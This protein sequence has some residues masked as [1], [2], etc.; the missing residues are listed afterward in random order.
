MPPTRC[1]TNRLH[2]TP[3]PRHSCIR[4]VSG[5]GSVSRSV[6]CPMNSRSAILACAWALLL[7]ACHSPRATGDPFRSAT[8]EEWQRGVGIAKQYAL[9][10]LGL[11]QDQLSKLKPDVGYVSNRGG[12]EKLELQFYDPKL[13]P[14]E[15]DTVQGLFIAMDGGFP[16]YFRI[17]IDPHSW[18]VCD[19]YASP[20]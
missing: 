4:S 9:H 15:T 8:P 19:H 1:I 3:R 11:S 16:T 7:V 2:R 10:Q 14:E 5:A 17:T 20:M 18:R 6:R 12:R 13:Y